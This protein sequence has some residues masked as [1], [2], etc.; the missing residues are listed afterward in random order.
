MDAPSWCS[1]V[2]CAALAGAYAGSGMAPWRGPHDW[3]EPATLWRCA[4]GSIA[5]TFDDGPCP[6]GTPRVLDVLRESGARATFFLVGERA[7]A[8]PELVR[9]IDREGHAIG[10][11]GWRH[12]TLPALAARPMA[13]EIDR[14]QATLSSLLGAAPRLLR[15]PYGYRDFRVYRAARRRGLT[16]V[17]WSLDPRD[18][19]LSDAATLAQRLQR[20][21]PGDIVLLHDGLP[22]RAA[23]LAALAPLLDRLRLAGVPVERLSPPSEGSAPR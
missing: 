19:I 5:L 18:W 20:A 17:M 2:G 7:Q 4:P 21:G 12:R 1:L 14:C 15:P 6:R 23:M 10:N 3:F 22:Q 13:D 9:R 8:H 16:P 11:H